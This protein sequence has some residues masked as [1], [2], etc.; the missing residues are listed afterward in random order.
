V[1]D[2]LA[3]V[4]PCDFPVKV[5]GRR[6]AELERAVTEIV[7]RHTG[8]VERHRVS[9]RSSKDGNFVALTVTVAARSRA[10]LDELYRELTACEAVLMAL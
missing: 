5:L 4:F 10:Q 8:P 6:D 1:T 3:D 9:V 7:E 2:P